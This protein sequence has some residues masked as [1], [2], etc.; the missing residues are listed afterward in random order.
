VL[1]CVLYGWKNIR[2]DWHPANSLPYTLGCDAKEE[3]ED[4]RARL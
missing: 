2:Y 4:Y 1:C 3:M